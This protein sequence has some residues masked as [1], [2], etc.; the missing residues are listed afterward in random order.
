MK[1]GLA[2][3]ILTMTTVAAAQD[4]MA[5]S[6]RK[7]VVEEESKHNLNAA[8]QNYQAA[9]S[10]FDEARQTAA[11]ALFRIAE[12]YRKLGKDDQAMAAYKRVAQE[13]ADQTKL[14]E[15]SRN[16]LTNSYHTSS[17]NAS[18]G[19]ASA[20]PSAGDIA[21]AKRAQEAREH[22]RNSLLE[23]I[24]MI[25][26]ELARE[27]QLIEKGAIPQQVVDE[28]KKGLMAAQRQLYAFDAGIPQGTTK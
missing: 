6:L 19:N 18:A 11:T 4:R 17:G 13:F 10:Q 7:G 22:Y 27:Q 26:K 1:L 8:I 28:T 12:C 14:A 9:L 16:I 24:S 20:G 3:A 15:Q 5:D 23:Q 2:F 21:Q 25:E